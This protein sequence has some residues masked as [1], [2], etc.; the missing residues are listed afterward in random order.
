VGKLH[1]LG[2]IDLG[3]VDLVMQER[4]DLSGKLQE[5]VSRS[6]EPE[7]GRFTPA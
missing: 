3:F 4:L 2:P 7:E 6:F 5:S 1:L